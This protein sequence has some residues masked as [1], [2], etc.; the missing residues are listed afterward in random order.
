MTYRIAKLALSLSLPLL[1][2]DITLAADAPKAVKFDSGTISG[3]NARNIGSAEM[4]GRIAALAGVK[5]DGRT[6]LYVGS[7]SG[8]VWKS[9]DGGSNFRPI[10]D[11]QPVQSIG[12][13]TIDPS[14][15]KD[16]WVG[17]GES[18]AR[19]SVSMGDGVYKSTDGGDNWTNVGLPQSE[20][21]A[22][23]LVDPTD[24]NTI[25]ACVTGHGVN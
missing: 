16:V 11:R 9:V 5:E 18:W 10:F 21:I 20:R 25:Y 7:A 13:I 23:I 2:A 15:P 6:T 14:N 19:N 1:L 17:T 22:K 8:G 4:S 24:G 3:L 12:A